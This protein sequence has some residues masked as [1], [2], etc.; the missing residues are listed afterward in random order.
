[1]LADSILAR[2]GSIYCAFITLLFCPYFNPLEK[3]N[4][5]AQFFMK[6][7]LVSQSATFVSGDIK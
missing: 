5:M 6:F 3:G 1:M 4:V 7:A 2:H